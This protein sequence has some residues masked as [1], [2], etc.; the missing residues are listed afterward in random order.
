MSLILVRVPHL[1]VHEGTVN[2][3]IHEGSSCIVWSQNQY[4]LFVVMCY[5][6][7]CGGCCQGCYCL[8][9]MEELN[10]K[11]LWQLVD[12]PFTATARWSRLHNMYSSLTIKHQMQMIL[13]RLILSQ[14]VAEKLMYDQGTDSSEIISSLY[15]DDVTSICNVIARP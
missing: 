10:A 15:N 14:T 12:M 2:H 8:H 7:E 5:E 1:Q 9:P 3:F 11:A 6:C 13:F 4:R